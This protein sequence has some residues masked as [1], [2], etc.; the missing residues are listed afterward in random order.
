MSFL[1]NKKLRKC[2]YDRVTQLILELGATP[3]YYDHDG[4]LK[5][6]ELQTP[7]GLVTIHPP[8]PDD[9]YTGV[10][11]RFEDVEAANRVFGDSRGVWAHH[12]P[13]SGKYNCNPSVAWTRKAKPA[14]RFELIDIALEQVR[15]HFESIL[16]DREV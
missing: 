6:Y 12:N 9:Q 13:A 5:Q 15:K 7:V 11:A 4:S 3:V 1:S 10:C 8:N 2:W 16:W 14:E